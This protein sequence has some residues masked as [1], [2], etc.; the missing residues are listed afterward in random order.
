MFHLEITEVVLVDCNIFNNDYQQNSKVLHSYV[1][2]KSFGQSLDIS[3]KSVIFL[4]TFK[5]FKIHI[6]VRLTDKN[7]ELLEIEDKINIT[8]VIN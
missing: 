8:V 7:L 4:K 2:N 6:E 1:P 5:I 3:P